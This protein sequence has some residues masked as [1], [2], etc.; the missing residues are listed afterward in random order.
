MTVPSRHIW[1]VETGHC[2]GLYDEI[3]KAFVERVA[4]MDLAVGVRRTV[5]QQILRRVLARFANTLINADFLPQLE[6]FGLVLRQ[7]CLHGEVSLR[8]VQ[9]VFEF[10]GHSPLVIYSSC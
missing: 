6:P 1:R 8:Q 3:L 5:V 7:I 2:L 9:R 4:K 10:R